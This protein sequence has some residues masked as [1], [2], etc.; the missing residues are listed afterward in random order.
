MIQIAV[1]TKP[2]LCAARWDKKSA[3]HERRKH[4]NAPS[5]V[6]HAEEK[7][8]DRVAN[9]RAAGHEGHWLVCEGQA[10]RSIPFNSTD[11]EY[12]KTGNPFTPGTVV[13]AA[14]SI[15]AIS[16]LALDL[17]LIV[18]LVVVTNLLNGKAIWRILLVGEQ[19]QGYI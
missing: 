5:A 15:V 12:L 17:A 18:V 8:V 3:K 13:P 14:A 11:T 16:P 1:K 10:R 9:A 6:L 19:K 7:P 4:R 2:R